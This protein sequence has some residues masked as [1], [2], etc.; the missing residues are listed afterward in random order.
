MA[1][2]NDIDSQLPVRS[3][4]D[5]TD[6]RVL[7]K[8]QD[9]ADP[10]G[11]DKTMEISEKKAHVRNFSK[12]SDGNDQE[13][14]LSQEGHNLTN[15]D[16]DATNNKRPSSQGAI[17]HD[18]KNTGE[19][20]AEADQNMRPT[21]VAYDN[22]IDETVVSQDVALRDEDGVPYSKDNPLPVSVEES[23]GDEIHDHNESAAAIV[24]NNSDNHEY[25]VTALKEFEI[26]QW[27]IT[28]SGYM[29]GELFIET[30]VA[31]GVFVSKGVLFNSTANPNAQLSLKRMIKV[32]AGVKVRIT[33]TNLDNQSQ[34]L[35]SF[36]NGLES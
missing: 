14:L 11:V 10:G 4:A 22:G 36:V 21:A 34:A 3:L 30:A 27:G 13:V 35:Y 18:R 15:G 2:G 8:L 23:E 20:P 17:L 1:V 16:Y 19:V 12:D 5:G 32:A 33:R 6:E 7:V 28:A 25:T 29:K 26:E 24:K 31:S 9:G